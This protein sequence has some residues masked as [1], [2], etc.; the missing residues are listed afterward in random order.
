MIALACKNKQV[1]C[2][3]LQVGGPC[4]DPTNLRGQASFVMNQEFVTLDSSDA[5]SC[6]MGGIG[7][8]VTTDPSVTVT[9]NFLHAP[10]RQKLCTS[11]IYITHI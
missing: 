6:Y 2:S 1:D 8:I 3:A 5:R 11:Q 7:M 4:L 9:A 10:I